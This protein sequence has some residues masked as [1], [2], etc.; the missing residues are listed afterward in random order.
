MSTATVAGLLLII[1]P[2]SFNAAF[3]LLAA[4]FDYPDAEVARRLARTV[5]AR[6]W[7]ALASVLV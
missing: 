5:G 7:P 2:L 3:A 4:R 1:V 6:S